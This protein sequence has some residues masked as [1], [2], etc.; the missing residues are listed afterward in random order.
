MAIK[1]FSVII[2]MYFNSEGILFNPLVD[3]LSHP[4]PD[5]LAVLQRGSVD[6]P[7][8][9]AALPEVS[10]KLRSPRKQHVVRH[11]HRPFSQQTVFLQ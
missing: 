8:I 1:L 9:Q 4:I 2:N 10:E 5:A 11:N 3:Q 6:L 7:F